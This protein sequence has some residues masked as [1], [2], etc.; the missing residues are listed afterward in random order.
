MRPKL[1]MWSEYGAPHWTSASRRGTRTS[2]GPKIL[3]AAVLIVAAVI[4]VSGIHPQVIDAEWVQDS[5][6][7]HAGSNLP[8]VTPPTTATT[9]RRSGIV[10]AIPLPQPRPTPTTT[11]LAAVSAPRPE[12]AAEL[13]QSVAAAEEPAE[14]ATLA[15]AEI[16]DAEAKADAPPA[17]PAAAAAAKAGSKSGNKPSDRPRV[18]AMANKKVVRVEHHQRSRAT[19]AQYGGG[20]GG[21]GGGG[22]GF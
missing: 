10:A 11:G 17:K 2:I 9:P 4:G 21:W 14:T 15:L 22:W 16:P 3:L 19:Y 7:T 12:R 1:A 5:E 20:W 18:V 13:L 6:G 8:K